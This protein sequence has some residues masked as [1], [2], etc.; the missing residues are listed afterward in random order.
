M[1][2]ERMVQSVRPGKWAALEE[3]DKQYNAVESR[4]GFPPKRRYQLFFG[5]HHV[6]TLVVEREW[7]SMAAMEMTWMKALADPEE[8]ALGTKLDEIVESTQME[9]YY[10]LP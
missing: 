4:L 5:G 1:F 3:I 8:R 9:I 10:I 6:N 2:L 7:E